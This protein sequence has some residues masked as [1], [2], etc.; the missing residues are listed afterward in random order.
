MPQKVG[1]RRSI[2]HP[3]H[4]PVP[5]DAAVLQQRHAVA[6][7]ADRIHVVGDGDRGR[8]RLAHDAADASSR[9]GCP[10]LVLWGRHGAMERIYDVLGTWT[11]QG[12]DVRGRALD[13]GH[14]LA[15]EAPGQTARELLGLL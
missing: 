1:Q 12:V 6:D 9:I 15:E 5:G 11:D 2:I 3:H 14:F 7:R 10:L 8:A 4:R 13:S